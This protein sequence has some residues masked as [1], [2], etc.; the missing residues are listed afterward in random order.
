MPGSPDGRPDLRSGNGPDVAVE[1]SRIDLTWF[2]HSTSLITLEGKTFLTDPVFRNRILH[3][4]RHSVRP[5]LRP[6][7]D[8]DFVLISHHH[9]DHLDLPSLRM[10][11]PAALI[12]GPTGTSG[13]LARTGFDRVVELR[14]GETFDAEGVSVRAVWA[15]HQGRRSPLHSDVEAIGFV[16]EAGRSVY[17][18]GDTD[19]YP[20]MREEVGLTDV[21][22][23]PVWGWGPAVGPGHLDPEGAARALST[24]RPRFAV[25]IHWG[26]FFPMGLKRFVGHHLVVPPREFERLAADYA[27]ETDV[28]VI[29]PGSRL[30]LP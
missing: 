11:S 19:L 26:T 28:R 22:L 5:D 14:P 25:P 20:G 9:L 29:E 18:A 4:R 2:G 13:A 3:L 10:L 23:L 1:P 27:P 30:S 6:A 17:F 8:P 21:A 7:L 15:E 16:L 24:L 12:I